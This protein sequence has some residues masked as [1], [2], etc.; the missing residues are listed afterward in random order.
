M[1]V[2]FSSVFQ[3]GEYAAGCGIF[4]KGSGVNF[5]VAAAYDQYFAGVL[6]FEGLLGFQGRS[7]SSRYNSREN[8]VLATESGPVNA[9]VDF[10]NVGHVNLSYAFVQPSVKFYPFSSL[11][12]GAGTS[13]NFLL[14][15]QT[16]YE[17]NIISPTIT[18]DDLGIAEIYYPESESS[19]PYNKVFSPED[20]SDASGVT[21]DGV[22]MLGA[23]FGV[24][25]T[26]SNPVNPNPRKKLKIGPRIQYTIPLIPALKSDE[27][28]LSLGSLQFLVGFRYEL[29]F[30]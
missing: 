12:I 24:G 21:F 4:E 13:V 9:K 22:I 17:K 15:G 6:Q 26:I 1:E 23:E 16:Q 29:Y 10:E 2:G 3:Q 30:D 20:R 5:F 19:D 27:R 14:S 28:N 8:L 18:L 11:Y 7:I 25:K